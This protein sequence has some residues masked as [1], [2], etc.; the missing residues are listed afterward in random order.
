M[1]FAPR[2]HALFQHLSFQMRSEAEVFVH[3]DFEMRFASQRRAIFDLSISP[4]GSALA[5]FASLLF[6]PPEP[7]NI[8]KTSFLPFRMP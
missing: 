2:R 5:A 4:D 3:F 8:G 1:C 7:Q 6:D